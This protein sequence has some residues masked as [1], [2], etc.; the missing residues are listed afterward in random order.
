[1][2]QVPDQLPLASLPAS[3]TLQVPEAYSVSGSPPGQPQP[4]HEDELDEPQHPHPTMVT[5]SGIAAPLRK[6]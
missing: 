6:V 5:V 2:V 3:V 1:M 4:V